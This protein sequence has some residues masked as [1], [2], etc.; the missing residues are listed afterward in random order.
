[1]SDEKYEFYDPELD[2]IDE[3]YNP[4]IEHE[5][6]EFYDPELD[7]INEVTDLIKTTAS[8]WHE[9]LQETKKL[10]NEKAKKLLPP[11]K[12]KLIKHEKYY[13]QELDK[14]DKEDAKKEKI[15]IFQKNTFKK[16]KENKEQKNIHIRAQKNNN[17]NEDFEEET[18]RYSET[19]EDI[20]KVKKQNKLYYEKMRKAN[21]I[22]KIKNYGILKINFP[23]DDGFLIC[24]STR[25]NSDDIIQLKQHLERYQRDYFGSS[26]K[27]NTS[28]MIIKKKYDVLETFLKKGGSIHILKD[29][30]S[31]SDASQMEKEYINKNNYKTN[32]KCLNKHL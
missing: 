27:K 10:W 3:D 14:I 28:S 32:K 7:T 8:H 2:T 19:K 6:Y 1:M 31:K 24:K 23:N 25:K 30:L 20:I 17:I 16:L 22:N 12:P 26:N 15:N 18:D 21:N 5:K 13:N 29:N 4:S 11:T 9:L